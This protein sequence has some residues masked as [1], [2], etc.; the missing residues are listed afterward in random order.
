MAGNEG[1]EP[2]MPDSESG[3]LPLGEFPK[4]VLFQARK[5]IC[6]GFLDTWATSLGEFPIQNSGIVSKGG[7]FANLLFLIF[8]RKESINILSI[9]FFHEP[10]LF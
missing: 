2:P 6:S 8:S 1:F 7:I 9:A 10:F 4:D 3:A 5:D